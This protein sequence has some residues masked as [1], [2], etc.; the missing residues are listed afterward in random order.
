MEAK[1]GNVSRTLQPQHDWIQ[2]KSSHLGSKSEEIAPTAGEEPKLVEPSREFDP[3]NAAR[4]A[5]SGY[6]ETKITLRSVL[7]RQ[8]W[9]DS[10]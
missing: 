3:L 7:A 4:G 9:C 10:H 2:S 5:V 8:G 1:V 6:E